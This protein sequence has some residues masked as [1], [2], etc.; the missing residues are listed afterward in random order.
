M[1]RSF[2]RSIQSLD[3]VFEFLNEFL[4]E[5]GINDGDAFTLRFAVE[6]LFTNLVK[7][8]PDSPT[9]ITLSLERNEKT[10]IVQLVDYQAKAFDPTKTAEL[11]LTKRLEERRPGGL[12]IHLVK[13][14]IDSID[15]QHINN[16][17]I[18]T[19]THHVE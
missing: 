18:I 2:R 5:H 4:R 10:V 9:E 14:M 6:E 13:K 3:P 7:Y 15:Y 8:N 12:G 11:D 16:Q 19:L 17:S 1:K